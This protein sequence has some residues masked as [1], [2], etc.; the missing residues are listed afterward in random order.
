MARLKVVE[1]KPRTV[2]ADDFKEGIPQAEW[3]DNPD[4]WDKK[5]FVKEISNYL[6]DSHGIIGLQ[7]K[8]AL[9]VLA[10]HM[11]MYIKCNK[12]LAVEEMVVTFNE[13]KTIGPNPNITI[14]NTTIRT[15]I[16]LMK[17]LGLTPKNRLENK[18]PEKSK[19]DSFLAGPLG[20]KA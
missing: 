11:D 15:I 20:I 10:D 6:K 1:K 19:V 17:E 18:K 16:D 7:H 5:K 13:G 12:A 14:R 3:M 4:A 9:A 8:H 2:L